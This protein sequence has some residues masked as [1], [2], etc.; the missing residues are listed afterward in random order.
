MVNEGGIRREKYNSVLKG[1]DDIRAEHSKQVAPLRTYSKYI[2]IYT[3][4]PRWL[5]KTSEE[6]DTTQL[7][8]TRS[9]N[10][11]LHGINNT[12]DT[13]IAR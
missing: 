11:E 7:C 9:S 13:A 4:E 8:G 10:A 5:A 6:T 3:T 1:S 12:S 2:H